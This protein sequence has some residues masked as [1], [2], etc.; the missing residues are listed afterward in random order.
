M[1]K[2]TALD[3]AI[4]S[5]IHDAFNRRDVNA[6]AAELTDDVVFHAI[7]GVEGMP[8]VLEGRGVVVQQF[9]A[10]MQLGGQTIEHHNAAALAGYVVGLGTATFDVAGEQRRMQIVDVCRL[11]DGKLAERWALLDCPDELQR[12]LAELAAGANA[13]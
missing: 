2:Q 12:V 5:R 10:M 11:R 8:P 4:I 3:T 13:S 9:E 7:P 1:T 6:I